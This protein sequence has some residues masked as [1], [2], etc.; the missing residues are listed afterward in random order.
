VHVNHVGR[1]P[2]YQLLICTLY[3]FPRFSDQDVTIVS[4]QSS[5]TE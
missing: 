5:T 4:E 2:F 3:K 1:F